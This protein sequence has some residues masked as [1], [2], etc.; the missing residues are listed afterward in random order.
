MI[1][2]SKQRLWLSF[3]RCSRLMR[4]ESGSTKELTSSTTT[5]T[6]YKSLGRL[7]D[8][9]RCCGSVERLSCTQQCLS[10]G[11]GKCRKPWSGISSLEMWPNFL[12]TIFCRTHPSHAEI[13]SGL[14]LEWKLVHKGFIIITTESTVQL[15]LTSLTYPLTVSSI[16]APVVF[17]SALCWR[18]VPLFSFGGLLMSWLHLFRLSWT[19]CHATSCWLSFSC[20]PLVITSYRHTHTRRFYRFYEIQM[21]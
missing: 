17:S 10:T 21:I 14:A 16:S 8:F 18:G 12:G 11:M 3:A 13:Y 7:K 15:P 4:G 19:R 1:S 2:D 9:C 20:I 5:G 6:Q